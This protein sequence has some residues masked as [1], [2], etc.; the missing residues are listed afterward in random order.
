MT[1]QKEYEK[2][3]EMRQIF[4]DGLDRIRNGIYSGDLIDEIL[5]KLDNL[6]Q[7]YQDEFSQ[8]NKEEREEFI[9]CFYHNLSR[10]VFQQIVDRVFPQ[11]D[12]APPLEDEIGRLH[13]IAKP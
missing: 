3:E 4:E 8:D 11:M 13:G 1:D 6:K 5:E 9:A 2:K 10:A 7:E 12:C